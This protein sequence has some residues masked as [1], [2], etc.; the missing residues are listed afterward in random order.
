MQQNPQN[1][2]NMNEKSCRLAIH[3]QQPAIAQ[4]DCKRVHLE[5]NLITPFTFKKSYSDSGKTHEGN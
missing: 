4:E 3:H 1:L 2:F 5:E